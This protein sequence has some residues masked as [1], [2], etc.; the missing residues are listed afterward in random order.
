[1]KKR[2]SKNLKINTRII[3][4]SVMAIVIPLVIIAVS[5]PLLIST[6]ASYFNFSTVTTNTFGTVNQMQWNQT[7]SG[8]ANELAGDDSS[9]KKL[10]SIQGF[11]APLERLNSLIYIECDGKYFYSTKNGGDVL[12]KANRIVR[13][14]NDRNINY[15]SGNGLVI[16]NHTDSPEG[17]YRVVI[18]NNDYT[19]ND[20]SG[21]ISVYELRNLLL[22]RTGIIVL[23]IVLLF[24]VSITVL[25]FITS[26]TIV[27]PIK[28]IERG[29]DEIARG[30]LDYKIEYKS[31]NELGRTVDSFNKM[32]ARLK[33]S[34]EQ[35]NKADEQRKA[36]VAGIAH[37]LRT[38]LTSAKGYAQG[39]LDG[40]ADSPQKQMKYIKTICSSIDDTERILDDLLTVSRMELS[41]YRLN[42]NNVN[43]VAFFSDCAEEISAVL[44]KADFSF[45]YKINCAKNTEISVD[46]DRFARVIGNIISNCI[47]YTREDVKGRVEM[48]LNE[49]ESSVILEIS[50]NGIGV[51]RESISKIFD[52]MYRADPARSKV[53]EGSGLGLSVCKQIIE[54]HGG[55]IWANSNENAGLS[56]FISLP[57]EEMIK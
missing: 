50:D 11:V 33:Q 2:S 42:K 9:E 13:I 22:G 25:S 41:S 45:S 40:I 35:Q 43:A 3:I 52:I 10:R 54:L 5:S 14:D 23:I 20:A 56:I 27:S 16:V 57:K 6:T 55:F 28:K 18:V 31:T 7:V 47:K 29:A 32:R 39:L 44:E 12:E 15:F 34:I 36:L 17:R 30:N 49:Y 51:D 37:D 48:T 24:I 21:R 38:P 53:S 19:V 26:K 4:S 46:T 1:M 8:I